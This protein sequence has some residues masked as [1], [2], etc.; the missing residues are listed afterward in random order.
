M[1]GLLMSKR[2]V[3][4]FKSGVDFWPTV[5]NW[6]KET[7]YALKESSSTKRLYQKGKGMW[8]APM[9]AE[10]S[11]TGTDIHLEAWIRVSIF[12]RIMGLFILPAEMGIESGG[13][14][15]VVP[16]DIARTAVN[17]LLTKINQ[18]LIQ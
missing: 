4:D 18:P 11:Q 16:R 1:E 14:K 12:N 7:G 9:M 5:D 3:R 2:T 15:G 13:L 8:V 6:A 17:K 10:I